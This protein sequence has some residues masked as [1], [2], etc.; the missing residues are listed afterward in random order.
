MA[1]PF[2]LPPPPAKS[3]KSRP[4]NRPMQPTCSVP[5]GDV[6]R[7]NAASSEAMLWHG[8]EAAASRDAF[9]LIPKPEREALLA[10]V[11]SL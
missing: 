11:S 10:F 3:S 1:M 9:L 4:H 8:G 6:S 7:L 5:D 2:L